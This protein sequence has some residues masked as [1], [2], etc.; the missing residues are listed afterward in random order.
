[1]PAIDYYYTNNPVVES[2]GNVLV[3]TT[4]NTPL[5]NFHNVIAKRVFDLVFSFVFLVTL[6]PVIYLIIGIIIKLGSPGP[7]FFVQERTGKNGATFKCYKFRSMRC[8]DEANTKQATA[9]DSRKTRVGNFL[10]KTNLDD[11][12]Q[13]I[14]VLKGDMSIVGPRPHM[15]L[16]TEEYS[17]LVN[18]YMVRHFIKPGVTGWAQINGCRGETKEVSQMEDRIR[19]DIWYLENWSFLLDIEIIIRTVFVTFKGDVKAY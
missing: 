6:F 14:N 12:P 5:D 18:K 19:K 4:Q 11:L 15:L 10:R 17:R 2:I 16:H 13:F 1:V 9:N 7:V 3:F 8:N